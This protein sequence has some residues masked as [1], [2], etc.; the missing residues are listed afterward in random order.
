MKLAVYA[1][2]LAIVGVVVFAAFFGADPAKPGHIRVFGVAVYIPRWVRVGAASIAVLSSVSFVLGMFGI[3]PIDQYVCRAMGLC[4]GPDSTASPPTRPP[5]QRTGTAAFDSAILALAPTLMHLLVDKG[6]YKLAYLCTR[7]GGNGT[8]L[9]YVRNADQDRRQYGLYVQ[10]ANLLPG[11]AATQF[12]PLIDDLGDGAMLFTHTRD[13]PNLGV[14]PHNLARVSVVY[15]QNTNVIVQAD[16][17][18]DLKSKM[19]ACGRGN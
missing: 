8:W 6:D 19:T 15:R 7:R 9:L 18:P 12:M 10:F 11:T 2:Q 1:A 4:D 3:I 5:V 14:T 13:V 16:I 17:S